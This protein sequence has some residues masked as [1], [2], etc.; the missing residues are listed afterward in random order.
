MLRRLLPVPERRLD[1]ELVDGLDENAE[2]VRDDLAQYLV[3]LRGFGLRAK[4]AAELRLDYGEGKLD[5]RLLDRR[6]DSVVRRSRSQG[7]VGFERLA[8]VY[9]AERG[10]GVD[11]ERLVFDFLNTAYSY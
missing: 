5:V 11:G 6:A 3:D 8:T 10:E 1:P 7:R 4:G 9:R 2:V